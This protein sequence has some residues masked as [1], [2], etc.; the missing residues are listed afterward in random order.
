M[1]DIEVTADQRDRLRDLQRRLEEEMASPYATVRPGDAVAYLLDRH[2]AD[3]EVVLD[4]GDGAT[5]S[6]T[7][8][9][10]GDTA[11]RDASATDDASEPDGA[12]A[13]VD[14]PSVDA[15][16]TTDE[17]DSGPTTASSSG[18]LPSGP[19]NLLADHEDVWREGSGEARYEVELPDGSVEEARTRGDVRALLFEHYR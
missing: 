9:P 8:A 17:S 16:E 5:E 19:M 14:D 15:D 11:E 1:P 6:A 18:D 4:D 2:A 13:D 3:G 10:D 7:S 12:T